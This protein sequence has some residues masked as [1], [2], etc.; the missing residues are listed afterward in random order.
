MGLRSLHAFNHEYASA[1]ALLKVVFAH[2]R[3]RPGLPKVPSYVAHFACREGSWLAAAKA[4]GV[5]RVMG[6]DTGIGYK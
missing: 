1:L 2:R 5:V 3:P 6:I 4:S